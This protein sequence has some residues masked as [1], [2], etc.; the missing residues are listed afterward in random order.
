MDS[1]YF[2]KKVNKLSSNSEEFFFMIDYEKLNPIV[3]SKDEFASN[4]ILFKIDEKRNY[5]F[6][7]KDDLK[8]L[9]FKKK[10][11]DLIDYEKAFK[12][13]INHIKFG[14][15]YLLNLTFPTE[16]NFTSSFE[17]I[18]YN[19]NSTYKVLMKNSFISFSPECF[20]KIKKNKI[21]SYPMKGTISALV[22]DAENKILNN[23]KELWE[24]NT[25][26]DL[27]RNDLATY[28]SNIKVTKFRYLEKVLNA[29]SPLLQVVSEVK[30][31]LDKNWKNYLGNLIWEMLPAGSISGAPKLK[32]IDV[33]RSVEK[34]FRGYYSGVYGYFDG[35]SLDSA[36]AIRFI[37]KRNDKFYYRSGGG[38]TSNSILNEEYDELL[39]KIYVPII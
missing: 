13:V 9:N 20:I 16:I 18:F 11:I 33:I 28:A 37:E 38:I 10:P 27:I 3:L 15:T 25:I 17:N 31:D 1:K 29:V 35:S 4:Q 7:I 6:S 23:K 14:D 8:A 36:V 2:I 34:D 5:N 32:T 21:F 30:G 39:K 19:A 12:K 22:K 24:H 26:V